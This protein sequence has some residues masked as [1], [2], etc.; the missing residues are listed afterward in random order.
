MIIDIDNRQDL[1]DIE[2]DIIDSVKLAVEEC[3]KYEL[4]STDYELSVSFVSDDE[5]RDIN[6]AYRNIDK[7]TDVLSFPLNEAFDIKDEMLGD[8]IISPQRAQE[9]AKEYGNSLKREI[10]YLTVHS[11][12][13]LFGYDHM[14]ESDKK[15]MRSKEKKVIKILGV[16]KGE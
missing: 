11:M 9:Q 1:V 2:E 13:H 8:I 14:I 4:K 10:V 3:L 16:Y 12:F 5:I 6:K 15:V 7:V